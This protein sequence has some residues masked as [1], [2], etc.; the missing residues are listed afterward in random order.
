MANRA[1]LHR[2]RRRSSAVVACFAYFFVAAILPP[3]YMAAPL[4]SGTAFH[5]CPGDLRSAQLLA[6]MGAGAGHHG[7][8]HQ[9]GG[10]GHHPMPAAEV[11]VA[12]MHG[13]GEHLHDASQGSEDHDP[14]ASAAEVRFDS[15]CGFSATGSAA[16][17]ATAAPIDFRDTPAQPVAAPPPATALPTRWL[18]PAPRSP[19]A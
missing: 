5:L 18:R 8:D 16:L 7:G 2:A 1:F 3:G 17:A 13:P 6:A 9:D 4:A 14:A 19:P 12:G 11:S 10:F 15:G